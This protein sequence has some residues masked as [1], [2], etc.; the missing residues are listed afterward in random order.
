MRRAFA[1]LTSRLVLTAV[2]LVVVVAVLI[3][4]ATTLALNAQLNHQI[5]DNLKHIGG[6]APILQGDGLP[7][8]PGAQEGTMTSSTRVAGVPARW[9][10]S[11]PAP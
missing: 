3:G 5:D 10:P 1:S 2:A 6:R 7:P 4:V 11:S 9:W 8:P